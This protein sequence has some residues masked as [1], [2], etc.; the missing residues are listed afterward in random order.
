M[1]L[2]RILSI[3]AR[4][5]KSGRRE[6]LLAYIILAPLIIAIGFRLFIPSVSAISYKFA[7]DEHL[8]EA[9]IGEFAQYGDVEEMADGSA[10]EERVK[11]IDDIVGITLNDQGNYV[12]V[13]E[14]NEE[15][16]L[17]FI[18]RQIVNDLNQTGDAAIQFEF[19]DIG[20]KMSPLTLF[21]AAGMVVLAIV[22]GGMII[23]L[24]IIEEKDAG[25]ISALTAS[26]MSKFEFIAGKSLIGIIFPVVQTYIILWLFGLTKINLLMVLVM[27]LISS[28]GTIILGFLIGV[29]SGNQMAGIANMKFIF[30]VVSGSFVGAM[31]LPASKH[32]FLYWSP[33]Y[34]SAMGLIE[35]ISKTATWPLIGKHILWIVGL[36]I[37]FFVASRK[38]IRR[39]LT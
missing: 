20:T 6:F 5:L 35:I 29:L 24:N 9:I 25:T 27:T 2:K 10:V 11:K 3:F 19:S 26:P 12:I 18:A 30:M 13:L 23:G 34:W 21:G 17:S 14:G 38:I 37:V 32:F 33:I 31:I 28:L 4:D 16:S 8:G 15:E 7:V 39:G 36:T 22:F 1:N